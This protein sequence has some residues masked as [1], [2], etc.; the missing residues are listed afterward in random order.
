MITSVTRKLHIL[1]TRGA[2]EATAPTATVR[3]N[4]VTQIS[5]TI[6]NAMAAAPAENVQWN[7]SATMVDVTKAEAIQPN[8]QIDIRPNSAGAMLPGA[9]TSNGYVP[10][11]RSHEAA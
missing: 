6:A 2:S 1:R 5:T 8:I 9:T 4:V 3:K 11:S 10:S 7:A